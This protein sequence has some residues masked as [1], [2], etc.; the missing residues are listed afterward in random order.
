MCIAWLHV[1]WSLL[2]PVNPFALSF[3]LLW[4][5][6]APIIID[7]K[8]QIYSMHLCC[9]VQNRSCAHFFIFFFSIDLKCQKI[10]N[11]RIQMFCKWPLNI[12]SG[13]TLT[14]QLEEIMRVNLENNKVW[15]QNIFL[16]LEVVHKLS[17]VDMK[18]AYSLDL[19]Y[20]Q[21]NVLP[22]ITLYITGRSVNNPSSPWSSRK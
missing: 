18:I 13:E 7:N 11:L 4:M 2:E 8:S 9:P 21:S 1:S 3:T 19:F 14:K 17:N 15:R 20:S 16:M 22:S 5:P 6:T 12:W 10:Y